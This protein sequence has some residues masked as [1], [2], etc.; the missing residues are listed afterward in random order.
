MFFSKTHL[1]IFSLKKSYKKLNTLSH[2]EI[3]T[4]KP[5]NGHIKLADLLDRTSTHSTFRLVGSLGLVLEVG[6]KNKIHMLQDLTP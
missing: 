5:C 1:N 3:G 6:S 2:L 4:G